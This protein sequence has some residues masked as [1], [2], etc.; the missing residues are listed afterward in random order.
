MLLALKAQVWCSFCAPNDAEAFMGRVSGVASGHAGHAGH[1][2][3]D[4]T[5]SQK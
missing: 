3:H 1:A 5:F 4:Q 2:E